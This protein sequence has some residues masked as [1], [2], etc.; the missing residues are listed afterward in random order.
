MGSVSAGG[1]Q[2][3]LS[4]T[5]SCVAAIWTRTNVKSRML[6]DPLVDSCVGLDVWVTKHAFDVLCVDFNIEVLCADD[7]DA[8]VPKGP[9]ETVEL[10]FCL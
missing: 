10:N 5:V 3:S 8:H 6:V 1:Q 7:V 2:D 9:E 4:A